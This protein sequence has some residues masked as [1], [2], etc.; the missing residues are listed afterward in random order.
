LGSVDELIAQRRAVYAATVDLMSDAPPPL[1]PEELDSP[2]VRGHLGAVLAGQSPLEPH[3][4][5]SVDDLVDDDAHL[6]L[7]TQP[8]R[9]ACSTRAPGVLA[10][11]LRRIGREL[12][13]AT[14]SGVGLLTS[15]A[16]AFPEVWKVFRRGV[17]LAARIAPELVYDLLPHVALFGVTPVEASNGLGSASAREFP[18]LIIIP[19]P[20]SPFE[21]AEAVVH[22]GAHQKFFDLAVTRA[23]LGNLSS[24]TPLFRPPWAPQGSSAW[25]LEQAFAA[26]HAYCCLTALGEVLKQQ[27]N[28]RPHEFSLVPQASERAAL[29]GDWL[30]AH[31]QFLG[32]DGHFLVGRLSGRSPDAA[33]EPAENKQLSDLTSGPEETVTRSCGNRTLVLRRTRPIELFWVVSGTPERVERS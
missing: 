1:G 25:P 22:E 9:L 14:G 11:A 26:F 10:G 17:E 21:V 24:S 3:A 15:E 18:G 13:G 33:P 12:H 2:A 5:R 29:I 27:S 28:V 31:G 6:R 16:P 30:Q 7:G 4:L 19:E 23:L 8:V 32:V 20:A